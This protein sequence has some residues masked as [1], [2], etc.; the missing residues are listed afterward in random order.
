MLYLPY[1]INEKVVNMVNSHV[2]P[3]GNT[4]NIW[5]FQKSLKF[6]R[7]TPENHQYGSF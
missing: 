4:L 3:S 5:H 2:V 6:T 7:V 1:S